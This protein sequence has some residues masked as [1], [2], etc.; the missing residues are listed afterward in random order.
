MPS[1]QQ[2]T[3]EDYDDGIRKSIAT[4]VTRL[5]LLCTRPIIDNSGTLASWRTVLCVAWDADPAMES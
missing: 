3:S 2:L 5:G 1:K 4:T